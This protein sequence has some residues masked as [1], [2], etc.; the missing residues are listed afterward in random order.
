MKKFLQ[1]LF[2]TIFMPWTGTA[3]LLV[4]QS[5]ALTDADQLQTTLDTLAYYQ[6]TVQ[7][8]RITLRDGSTAVSKLSTIDRLVNDELPR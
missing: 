1:R 3:A 2:N 7:E 4:L 5:E 6:A 8:I